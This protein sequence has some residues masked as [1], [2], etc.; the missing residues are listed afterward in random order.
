MVGFLLFF[1]FYIA[2]IFNYFITLSPNIKSF[3]RPLINTETNTT[4]YSFIYLFYLSF[5]QSNI[6][7]KC[8]VGM[9]EQ[10]DY[11]SGLISCFILLVC[12]CSLVLKLLGKDLLQHYRVS[13]MVASLED[14]IC[15]HLLLTCC[16]A[17]G[18][19]WTFCQPCVTSC[20]LFPSGTK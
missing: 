11:T 19:L 10:P 9:F 18:F 17:A 7:K 14:E 16:T 12:F 8:I 20:L 6:G 1:F 2:Y 13:F 3:C 4:S 5:L 15:D